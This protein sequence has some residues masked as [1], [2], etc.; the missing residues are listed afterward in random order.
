MKS[1]HFFLFLYFLFPYFFFPLPSFAEP[2]T[3]RYPDGRPYRVSEDGYR[4]S[5]HLAEL[6]VSI[7]DLKRQVNILEDELNKK[8]KQLALARSGSCIHE[9]TAIVE[10]NIVVSAPLTEK[11]EKPTS[12]TNSADCQCITDCSAATNAKI[13]QLE[14][15][16]NV[17]RTSGQLV[18]KTTDDQ[19]LHQRISELQRALM[20]GP[21]K[22]SLERE[23]EQR[24]RLETSLGG[25]EKTLQE[26]E[27]RIR[28][29]EGK[30]DQG[31]PG[32]SGPPAKSM[33][34][35]NAAS[36]LASKQSM[37]SMSQAEIIQ[38]KSQ[39]QAQLKEIQQLI[40]RRKA[41]LDGLKGSGKGVSVTIQLLVT[42]SG[43]TLDSVRAQVL[44]LQGDD[45]SEI[46]SSLDHFQKLLESDIQVLT[47][48][49][50]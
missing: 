28:Y 6:E 12:F 14:R 9:G 41:L 11:K 23:Q 50:K 15:D 25:L 29:L 26:K 47:R 42:S 4:L 10:K 31:K 16:L 13:S 34:V 40:S 44:R 1:H 39:Y 49:T 27:N 20:E 2:Q 22:E 3:G 45:G 8:D 30:L 18:A 43:K 32:V 19:P 33:D 24:A 46:E 37:E 36:A 35:A 38:K 7:E 17:A 5:D 48:L 21:S